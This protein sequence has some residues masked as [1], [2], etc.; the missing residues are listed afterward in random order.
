MFG[1]DR[2]CGALC[3][4]PHQYLRPTG[5]GD[6]DDAVPGR[7]PTG[8]TQPVLTQDPRDRITVDHATSSTRAAQEPSGFGAYRVIRFVALRIG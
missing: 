4:I 5:G 2:P 7:H 3:R 6:A 8:R 1:G